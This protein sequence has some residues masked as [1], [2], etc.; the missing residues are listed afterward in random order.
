MKKI[1]ILLTVCATL[2]TG[3]CVPTTQPPIR[4]SGGG[5]GHGDGERQSLSQ[6]RERSAERSPDETNDGPEG[7]TDSGESAGFSAI[8]G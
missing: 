3:A 6:S 5:G 1:V 4:H 2:A 7:T 8:S